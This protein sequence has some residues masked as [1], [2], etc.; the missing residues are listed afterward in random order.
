VFITNPPFTKPP[1]KIAMVE[2]IKRNI[3]VGFQ[4]TSP[5]IP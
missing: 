5:A 4:P 2:N 3:L 1:E